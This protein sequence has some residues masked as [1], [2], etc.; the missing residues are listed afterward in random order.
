[1]KK[2]IISMFCVLLA[3]SANTQ[4]AITTAPLGDAL[5][6]LVPAGWEL[7]VRS[8]IPEKRIVGWKA[9]PDWQVALAQIADNHNLDIRI[10]SVQKKVFVDP[11]LPVGGVAV[12]PLFSR[13][14]EPMPTPVEGSNP[15]GM[16]LPIR[17]SQKPS[18]GPRFTADMVKEAVPGIPRFANSQVGAPSTPVV[19]AQPLQSNVQPQLNMQ[20]P[21]LTASGPVGSG[22]GLSAAS[23]VS[24]LKA[25][26]LTDA[27][28]V[29]PIFQVALPV[30][31]VVKLDTSMTIIPMP[32]KAVFEQVV[33]KHGY[34][35]DWQIDDKAEPYR[36][37]HNVKVP[38]ESLEADLVQLQKAFGAGRDSPFM[39]D[40]AKGNR[41]VI[42]TERK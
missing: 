39:L 20:V 5:N 29:V 2:L 38:G 25:T 13:F 9:S 15:I 33:R 3:S 10:N 31:P 32:V 35:P 42:I 41:V 11:K 22:S 18:T 28:P 21:G 30:A 16:S 40:V 8:E 36:T 34:T 12:P 1:M 26:P 4:T 17:V 14:M 27:I 7:Y 6:K 23:E 24:G 19:V 37:S